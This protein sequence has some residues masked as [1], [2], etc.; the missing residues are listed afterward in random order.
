MKVKEL[1]EQLQSFDLDAMVVISGYEGGY[2][3]VD[4]IDNIKLKLN[5]NKA[6]YYGK[7]EECSNAET[8]AVRIC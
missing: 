5:V 2:S 7:H 3:E 1:I 6:W 8:T 4:S